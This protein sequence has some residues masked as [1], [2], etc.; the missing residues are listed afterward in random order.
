MFRLSW[1]QM[2]AEPAA[3]VSTHA[4]SRPQPQGKSQ[5]IPAKYSVFSAWP[6]N[7]RQQLSPGKPQEVRGPPPAQR[8]EGPKA[9]ANCSSLQ[10][11][12]HRKVACGVQAR[13]G[14]NASTH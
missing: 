8:A 4:V 13:K 12:S 11:I 10:C 5:E 2:P 6:Q 14:D 9:R 1:Q 3:V 7:T